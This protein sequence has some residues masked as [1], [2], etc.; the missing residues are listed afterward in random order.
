MVSDS[1]AT[2]SRCSPPEEASGAL[3]TSSEVTRPA[4]RESIACSL[5]T[6]SAIWK[7]RCVPS[8]LV[9]TLLSVVVS[10]W[11]AVPSY[12]PER[13][14]AVIEALGV[15]GSRISGEYAVSPPACDRT[16]M[17]GGNTISHVDVG[18]ML[19]A[20][21]RQGKLTVVPSTEM[22]RRACGSPSTISCT[23]DGSAVASSGWDDALNVSVSTF[24]KLSKAGVSVKSAGSRACRRPSTRWIRARLPHRFP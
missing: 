14:T 23:A 17:P 9:N 11:Y 21:S 3:L 24:E 19:L 2:L 5:S 16:K 12:V 13:P 22:S 1:A 15:S 6:P 18:P 7:K 4:S 8:G 10:A 20:S